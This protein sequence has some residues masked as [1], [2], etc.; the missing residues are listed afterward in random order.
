MEF[1]SMGSQFAFERTQA[2]SSATP[3]NLAIRDQVSLTDLEISD[4]DH[5]RLLFL[6]I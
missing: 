6:K 5:E 4:G 1:V 2:W 3:R